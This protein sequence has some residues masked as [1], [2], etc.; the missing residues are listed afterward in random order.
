MRVRLRCDHLTARSPLTEVG[1]KNMRL[2]PL[3][4][5]ALCFGGRFVAF[6]DEVFELAHEFGNVFEF[7]I[8]GRKAD[9]GH[10]IKL[11]EAAHYYF[12]ELRGL[13][14]AL[15]R[16]LN[17]FFDR[18]DYRFKLDGGNGAF[19]AGAKQPGHDLVA[20]EKLAAAVFFDDH[21]GNLVDSFVRR[22]SPAAFET[23]APTANRIAVLRLA[24]IN[25]LIFQKSA[26]WTLHN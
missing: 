16:V 7:E 12:P 20:L 13:A 15:R 2:L 5:L 21:V 23:L 6:A 1:L 9:V 18:I 17:V 3:P 26:K 22:K 14:L 10:L 24:R 19:F 4:G 8:D 25:N 11:F